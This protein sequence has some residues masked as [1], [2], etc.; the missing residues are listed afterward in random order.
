MKNK[1]VLMAILLANLF[2]ITLIAMPPD[3]PE[4]DMCITSDCLS[5]GSGCLAEN[6][7][8]GWDPPPLPDPADPNNAY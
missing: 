7:G 4:L 6:P 2:V 5:D 3:P 1:L 8:G